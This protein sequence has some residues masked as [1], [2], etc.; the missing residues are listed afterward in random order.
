[1][2]SVFQ[3]IL[4]TFL[5]LLYSVSSQAQSASIEAFLK[6]ELPGIEIKKLNSS[7]HFVEEYEVM[8]PQMIDHKDPKSGT[9]EQ[10]VFLSHYD[11]A[12]PILFVTEGYS[13]RDV[14]YEIA[15]NLKTNQIIVEYR[16]FGKSVPETI[17]YEYLNNTQ[18]MMD[19]HRIKLLFAKFYTNKNWI[20]TGISKGGTTC[21]FYK[22]AFPKDTR[23]AIPYVGPMPISATDKRMD[24]H[25]SQVGSQDC[26]QKLIDVQK[27]ILDQKTQ[28]I[29]KIDSVAKIK[30]QTFSMG[31]EMA[32]EYS[33]LE[34]SFSFWQYAQDCDKIP[35]NGT[36][37]ENFKFISSISGFDLYSDKTRAYYEPAFYQFMTENGYYGFVHEHL[38]DKIS[39]VTS[40]DNS[41]F[42]PQNVDLTYN[43]KY[44]L[45]AVNKLRKKKRILQIHGA[46]DP[47]SA[48]G[49][50]LEKKEQYYFVLEE[51][52]HTTR[53]T[54]FPEIEQTDIW[55]IIKGWL[56]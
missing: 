18:A 16:F 54:S 39:K 55:S 40:F 33:V 50:K 35:V 25:L 32:L 29:T 24:N 20:A 22:A 30:N 34:L 2:S 14:T 9:F 6:T 13:A 19:L 42:A 41:L 4:F 37:N 8:I 11:V 15:S 44:M 1:M 49:L 36:A 38:K 26:R 51:G 27:R 48:A 3:S 43:P 53:I 47:W 10:R 17:N 31:T 12:S 7:D 46:Y 28:I 5:S 56:K 52:S 23:M 45:K 21:L